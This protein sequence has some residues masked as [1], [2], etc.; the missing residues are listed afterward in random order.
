MSIAVQP[1]LTEKARRFGA[2]ET[3]PQF[4]QILLDSL[5]YVLDDLENDIGVSTTR[6]TSV[7][8]A[9]IDLDEQLYR[10][11]I[12]LG[13]DSYI[14][15][16]GEWTQGNAPGIEAKYERKRRMVKRQYQRS[17]DL[18]PKFGTWADDD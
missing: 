16:T 6:L 11:V 4:Q 12:S 3:A 7:S 1:L 17:L 2:D 9:D 13:L 18:K 15:D 14:T 8:G 10:G 5:N